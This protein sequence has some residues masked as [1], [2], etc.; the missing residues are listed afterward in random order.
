VIRLFQVA[1]PSELEL[2]ICLWS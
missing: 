2:W 1:K